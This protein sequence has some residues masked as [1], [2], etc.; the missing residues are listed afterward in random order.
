MNKVDDFTRRQPTKA[1]ASAAGFG[2]L[3]HLLPIGAIVGGLVSMSF[4]LLRPALLF[5]G[6]LKAFEFLRPKATHQ[7]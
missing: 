1:F 3:L 5:F 4:A 7:N 6:L 2:F